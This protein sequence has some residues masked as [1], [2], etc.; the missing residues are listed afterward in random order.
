MRRRVAPP[1][2]ARQSHLVGYR[3][4]C[5]I[6]IIRQQRLAS[7]RYEQVI[8]ERRVRASLLQVALEA[9]SG[10]LM[11]RNYP[12]LAELRN[13]NQQ[14]VRREIVVS[15]PDGLGDTKSCTGQ[16]REQRAVGLP[17]QSA[18]A[19]LR[20]QPDNLADLFIG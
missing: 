13:A 12:T 1:S 15:Q 14:P 19:R 18:I 5:S 4:E 11:Q 9:G 8:V 16:Q 3:P 20:C 2:S 10:S 7:Q 6:Y 17:A